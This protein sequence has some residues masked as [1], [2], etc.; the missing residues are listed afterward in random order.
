M[1]QEPKMNRDKLR[2]FRLGDTV[3][4]VSGPFTAFTGKIEGINQSKALLKVRVAIYGRTQPIKLNFSDAE[5]M[6]FR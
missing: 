3:R 5:V 1:D 2:T 6:T 4:I